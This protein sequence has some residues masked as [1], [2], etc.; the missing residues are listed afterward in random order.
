MPVR[1]K[2]IYDQESPDDGMR[3]LTTNYWPR[4]ISRERA[5]V[6]RRVLGPSRS[7]LR[8][9][10]DGEIAWPAYEV[11]YLEEM[12]AEAPRAE[13]AGLARAA[14]EGTV[15]VMCICR[16]EAECHRRLLRDLIEREIGVR[17]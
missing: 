16:D 17:A 5:G 12:R 9:F 3:V 2:S 14:R 11:R 15:T 4:G 13:I 1:S 10:K 7:L 8:A 6:Y